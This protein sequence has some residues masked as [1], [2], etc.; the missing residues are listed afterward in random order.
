MS[1]SFSV[2]FRV[3]SELPGAASLISG[4]ISAEALLLSASHLKAPFL[5]LADFLRQ[6]LHS[7]SR[8]PPEQQARLYHLIL[9][10][11]LLQACQG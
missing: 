10:A 6:I 11:A 7:A 1:F 5:M 8:G 4:S 2:V 3:T 9:L